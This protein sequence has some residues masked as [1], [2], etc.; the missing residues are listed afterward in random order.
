MKS[1]NFMIRAANSI[2][3]AAFSPESSHSQRGKNVIEKDRF[4][5][6]SLALMQPKSVAD[7]INA[8]D[9]EIPFLI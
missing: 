9:K 1:W 5:F 6:S 3:P 2:S 7:R 4:R 8:V